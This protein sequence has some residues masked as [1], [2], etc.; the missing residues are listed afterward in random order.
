MRSYLLAGNTAHY[1][2]VIAAF[3]ARGLAV[4]PAFAS[5]LDARPAV[6]QF[7]VRTAARG[8]RRRLAHRLLAG[9]RPRL[10]RR[11]G[12]RG[13]AGAGSTCPTSPRTP[14]E[15][16]TLEQWEASD[17]GLLPVEA[18]MMV[19]IPELDGATG[20]MVFGGRSGAGR[21]ARRTS[22]DMR[23][24]P[25]RADAA[26]RPRGQAGRAAAHAARRSAGS[27]SS[28]ST[29]RRMRAP[30]ARRPISA[31]F[32]SLHNTLKAPRR[33]AATRSRCRPTVD[34]AARLHH[35]GQRGAL[36]RGRER[37]CAHPCRRPCAARARLGRDRGAMGPGAGPTAERRR[38]DLRA[39]RAVR[40]RLVGVQPA[41]GYEGDPMR[42]LFEKG[43]APTHAFSAFYRCLREDFARPRRAAFR[44]PRRA[45]V[46]ARQAGR[47]VRRLLARPA[48]RRPAELLPLRR[49]QPFRGHIA[50]RRS[51][52]TLISYLTPPW[53]M[54]ASIAAC[55][56][57]RPRSSAGAG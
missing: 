14:V 35:R 41:F 42:L 48:D 2:G 15:F 12:G 8:R 54:P 30:P 28:C 56:T 10:Q 27:A 36:R 57:S 46:H 13:D 39:R 29:S 4:V 51:A 21:R 22:R 31:V 17:R 47:H 5:G 9:R 25:E 20:P 53:P 37:P 52:A 34:D 40:Q 16:Q 55:S 6:E 7:F 18:T 50:K 43:F 24:H 23:S 44:H 19:A 45:G 26:G 1:D 32:A 38:L 33:R 11:Q 49:Q 3:E